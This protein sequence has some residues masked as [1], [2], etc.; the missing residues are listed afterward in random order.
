MDN[1]PIVGET[2]QCYNIPVDLGATYQVEVFF[3]NGCV[4]SQPIT[5]TSGLN[6]LFDSKITL[7]P[8]P[9]NQFVTIE[10]VKSEFKYQL[11]D[12]NG[13]VI[14]MNKTFSK[15]HMIDI[16]ILSKG[17]YQVAI[18]DGMNKIIKQ[19]IKE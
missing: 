14:S 13:R 6:E 18:T 7:Y 19:F 11:M 10:S 12:L 2:Q 3:D 17:I 15:M 8:N 1:Q 16:S 9:A 5:M 4:L